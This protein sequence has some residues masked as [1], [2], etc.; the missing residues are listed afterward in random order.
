[1]GTRWF[2][3]GPS[4]VATVQALTGYALWVATQYPSVTGGPNADQELD[5]L[6]N[7]LEYA[8]GLDPTVAT[9]WSALPQPMRAGNTLSATY[10][11]PAGVTGV[12]YGAEW[13]RDLTVWNT[14]ADTGAGNTHTFNANVTGEPKVFFRHVITVAP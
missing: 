10:S 2:P 9:P 11:Q 4:K 13:S 12:T 8:F 7:G 1:M 5:G 6:R 14:I 3:Y